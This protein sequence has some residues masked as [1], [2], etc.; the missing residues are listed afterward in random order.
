[1]SFQRVLLVC[2]AAASLL[3]S[4]LPATT[5]VPQ[6]LAELSIRA[7]RIFTGEC[8]TAREVTV[9][10]GEGTVPA[11]EYEFLVTEGIR[12]VSTG[13]TITFRQVG[14]STRVMRKP[15]D[16]VQLPDIL[17][18]P[19]YRPQARYML[20]LQADNQ[21]GLTSPTGLNQGAFRFGRD[22]D[23]NEIVLSNSA[24]NT[25]LF[26]EMN[27]DARANILSTPLHT[28]AQQIATFNSVTLTASEAAVVNA[29][30]KK[31]VS[32]ETML[33]LTRKLAA[34]QPTITAE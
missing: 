10:V 18:M 34:A 19:E 22:L 20:F 17:M 29:P 24:G 16:P 8:V 12:G 13:Q 15:S 30:S 5:V 4:P 3:M 33:S 7:A 27:V 1:M 21:F 32:A 25:T 2:C 6:N 14:R 23:T 31:T 26:Y 28:S 9:Q 11:M